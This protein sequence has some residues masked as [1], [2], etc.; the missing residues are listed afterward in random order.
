MIRKGRWK[1]SNLDRQFDESKLELFDLD[2]EPGETR[3]MAET[4]LEK[5]QELLG[6]W[7]VER[8][9]LGI[10]LPQDL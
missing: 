6:L 1:L 4:N 9:R 3:D 8:K 10:V 7:R 2:A 5:Y